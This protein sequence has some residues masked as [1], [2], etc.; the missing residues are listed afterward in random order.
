M[1]DQI[2][3]EEDY[4]ENYV[5]T[6]DEINE[7]ARVIGLDPDSEKNL[8]WIAKEGIN[9]PLPPNWKPCQDVSGD[10][11]YFNFES[12]DSI[13]DHPC[14]EYYRGIVAR[15]RAKLQ[16]T[17][18]KSEPAK[19]KKKKKDKLKKQPSESASKM[20]N[21]L[22]GMDK[23][24][25]GGGVLSPIG[26]RP[27]LGPFVGTNLGNME[28]LR[29][30][31]GATL[32]STFGSTADIGRIQL[33]KLKTKDLDS[34]VEYHE[35]EDMD[36]GE[37]EDNQSSM[38]KMVVSSNSDETRQKKTTK[39][40]KPTSPG[41]KEG[42]LNTLTKDSIK[43]VVD[44]IEESTTV[45]AKER[46]EFN[47][48]ESVV[49][50]SKSLQ[51]K[52]ELEKERLETEYKDRVE[53]LQK[54][55]KEDSEEEEAK[56]KEEQMYSMVRLKQK[57]K[58]EAAQEESKLKADI[59]SNLKKLRIDLE[60]EKRKHFEV[61]RLKIDQEIAEKSLQLENEKR[62]E[63]RQLRI[64]HDAE[65][66][67]F[68]KREKENLESKKLQYGKKQLDESQE[69]ISD[70]QNYNAKAHHL[71]KTAM[72]E[73]TFSDK[74]HE[75]KLDQENQVKALQSKHN[76]RM[77][78]MR[79]EFDIQ[80]RKEKERLKTKMQY[81]HKVELNRLE[82]DLMKKKEIMT[83]KY[84]TQMSELQNDLDMLKSRRQHL[85]SQNDEI[86]KLSQK[87]DENIA[88]LK[89]RAQR[90]TDHVDNDFVAKEPITSQSIPKDFDS[91]L[92]LQDL[93]EQEDAERIIDG[94]LNDHHDQSKFLRSYYGKM[95]SQ[96]EKSS[97]QNA[98]DF[99]QKQRTA[100]RRSLLARDWQQERKTVSTETQ[101]LLKR[102]QEGF[103]QRD[104]ALD[105]KPTVSDPLYPDSVMQ[106][107]SVTAQED[108]NSSGVLQYLR[109]VDDKLNTVLKLVAVHMPNN[110]NHKPRMSVSRDL[111]VKDSS[112]GASASNQFGRN[113]TMPEPLPH[114]AF[115]E[116]WHRSVNTMVE[117]ELRN[118]SKYY[119]YDYDSSYTP[120]VPYRSA[121]DLLHS[122]D[123]PTKPQ[124][125]IMNAWATATSSSSGLGKDLAPRLNR[126]NDTLTS[127]RG[128]K[129]VL[130]AN[131]NEL[132]AVAEV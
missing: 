31:V 107:R 58:S 120:G 110:N 87:K 73:E 12:G 16:A 65:L 44:K 130:D 89:S 100:S 83:K 124:P 72:M 61:E 9:A 93:D 20:L 108:L 106:D 55:I 32:A 70:K 102:I 13:W 2:I 123:A 18:P 29:P 98:R 42:G 62:E 96:E 49:N 132:K 4:D 63:L 79:E 24:V 126:T 101:N 21:P 78:N 47:Y 6:E 10:I 11:Y 68:L 112:V 127:P 69:R 36:S 71:D 50:V 90:A 92:H 114:V 128:V 22:K 57:L 8:I 97:L 122:Y 125:E 27:G 85:N 40:V 81:E 45:A 60:N 3:L 30:S 76:E 116:S 86:S 104:I 56:L 19:K 59:Q 64:A 88:L 37:S 131:T 35:S 17:Q 111:P 23:P 105:T 26:Q 66:E 53:N 95:D 91:K 1:N 34:V 46:P 94:Q 5:P 7:Y 67:E 38:E 113:L 103:M 109:T 119:G 41:D 77:I 82:E 74:I 28:D 129:L 80:A 99:L 39:D 75:L 117:D 121:K 52:F 33:E 51:D 43:V 15:E 14:D 54:K 48:E 118:V 25:L 84:Q 115:Q